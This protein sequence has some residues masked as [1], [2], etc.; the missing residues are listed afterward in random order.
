MDRLG[1][2]TRATI[3][4]MATPTNKRLRTSPKSTPDPRQ[5]S[6]R[7]HRSTGLLDQRSRSRLPPPQH[8]VTMGARKGGALRKQQQDRGA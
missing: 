8:P 1:T 4:T 3:E 2:N 5:S 6:D 7:E